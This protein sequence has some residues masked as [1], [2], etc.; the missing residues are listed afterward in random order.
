MQ[1]HW[2]KPLQPRLTRAVEA[3]GAAHRMEWYRSDTRDDVF[4]NKFKKAA[5]GL[6]TLSPVGLVALALLAKFAPLT[7]VFRGAEGAY[8]RFCRLARLKSSE[9]LAAWPLPGSCCV[10]KRSD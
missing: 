3:R 9:D 2:S 1:R 7:G 8:S 5:I 6:S 4:A 10:V